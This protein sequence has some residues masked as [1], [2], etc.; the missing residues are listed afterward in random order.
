LE[1]AIKAGFTEDFDAAN[2]EFLNAYYE[3]LNAFLKT[4]YEFLNGGMSLICTTHF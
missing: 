2:Y 1:T 4:N 3:F